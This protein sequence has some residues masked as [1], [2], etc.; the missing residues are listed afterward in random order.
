MPVANLV[1]AHGAEIDRRT[2]GPPNGKHRLGSNTILLAAHDARSAERRRLD[3]GDDRATLPGCPYPE[4]TGRE[5]ATAGRS[6]GR[7]GSPGVAPPDVR[8]PAREA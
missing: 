3:R 8:A 7:P 1:G 6:L 5:P 4:R 2:G